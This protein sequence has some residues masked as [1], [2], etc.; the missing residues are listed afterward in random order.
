K[1]K[2]YGADSYA[3]QVEAMRSGRLHVAGISTGPTVFGV[4]LAGYVPIAIMGKADGRFGYKLQLITHKS[5]DIQKVSDLKGRKVAHVTPSSNSGNQAPRALFKSMGIVPDKDYKVTYSGKH[6]NSIMGVAN[7]DYEAAPIASSV[8]DRMVDKGVVKKDDLRIIWE[9]KNF[10]T[11]SYGY[12]HNLAPDLQAQI[13][14]AFLSFDWTGT[15]LKKEFG[16]K[17]DRF[18]P[19]T[20]KEHWID[21][22]TIQ[23]TNGTVYT[24]EALKGL[25]VKKKKKKKK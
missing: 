20:Y 23:K 19:I 15:A 25:K 13:K 24:D 8:L 17:S 12:A 22:R 3:A 11:T 14:D 16:K 10:P 1:V 7:K 21:I 2:W 6:D 5:T 4:N 9:S 18:I